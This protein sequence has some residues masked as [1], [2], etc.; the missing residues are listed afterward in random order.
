MM[1]DGLTEDGLIYG[2]KLKVFFGINE[3]H[4]TAISTKW[5]QKTAGMMMEMTPDMLY[6]INQLESRQ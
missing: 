3:T 1:M 2:A 6:F 5:E 4:F